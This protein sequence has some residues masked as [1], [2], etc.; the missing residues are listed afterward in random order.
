MRLTKIVPMAVLAAAI[1]APSADANY[2][3]G[4]SEQSPAMFNQPAWQSLKLKRVRYIVPWDY[5]KD[6]GQHNE[7]VSFMNTAHAAKQDVLVAFTARR[8]CYDNG[9]DSKAEARP[10]PSTS[11]HKSAR[12][13]LPQEVAYVETFSPREQ[14]KHRSQ[15]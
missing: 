6:A 13:R 4:L 15:P 8:G 10:A 1:G 2:R 12:T 5:Y 11:A 9:R 7:V 3:V 14:G